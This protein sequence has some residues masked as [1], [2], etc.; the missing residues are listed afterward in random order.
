MTMGDT[1]AYAI[2]YMQLF[3]NVCSVQ[4]DVTYFHTDI[5]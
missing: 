5:M 1:V 2:S 3:I 4:S